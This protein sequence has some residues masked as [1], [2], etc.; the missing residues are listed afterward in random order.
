[1]LAAGMVRAAQALA[2]AWF[3]T[4]AAHLFG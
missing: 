2:P 4:P 3:A 1:V